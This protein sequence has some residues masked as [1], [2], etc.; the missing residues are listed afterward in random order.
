[1]AYKHMGAPGTRACLSP[2]TGIPQGA[3]TPVHPTPR[4]EKP[5][6]GRADAPVTNL[7]LRAGQRHPQF[8]EP[9]QPFNTEVPKHYVLATGG[10]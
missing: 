2:P 1:M 7:G 10:G 3:H 6:C 4:V 8:A 9:S 5:A